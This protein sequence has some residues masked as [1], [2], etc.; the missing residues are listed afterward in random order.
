VHP[1]AAGQCAQKA[2][3]ALPRRQAFPT[4]PVL[5]A[6][7]GHAVDDVYPVNRIR[8]LVAADRS[9]VE[10]QIVPG[11]PTDPRELRAALQAQGVVHGLDEQALA[12]LGELLAAAEADGRAIVARA[13]PPN[14]GRDGRVEFAFATAPLP[15]Q[16]CGNGAVDFH[17]RELLHPAATGAEIARILPP[18]R[19]E[20]GHDVLGR[21]LPAPARKPAALRVGAGAAL[22]PD[23]RVLAVRDGFVATPAGAIDVLPLYAHKGD[24]DLKCGNL[25]SHGAVLVSGDLQQG[26]QIEADGDVAVAG[27]AFGGTIVAG[28]SVTVGFGAQAGSR[29]T[30]GGDLR[31]RHATNSTLL[32]AGKIEIRD[33]LVHCEAAAASIVLL[34]GRGSALGGALRARDRI[35][36]RSAGSPSG[37]PTLLAAGDLT[38]ERAELVRRKRQLERIERTVHRRGDADPARGKLLRERTAAADDAQKEKLDLLRRQR[39]LLCSARIE[40]HGRMHP[41]VRVQFGDAVLALT[42]ECQGM[43]FRFDAAAGT[44][45]Q[46]AR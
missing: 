8:V 4:A 26:F 40:V 25:H 44:I 31:C 7:R 21:P 29:I 18:E 35:A 20:D 45:V 36:L 9:A 22:Q 17:E 10:V 37:A 5:R 6:S 43:C 3:P 13:T 14:P 12:S 41:G 2:G 32:A 46:E 30:T 28:G 19:G 38:S 39:E 27:S 23:G 42:T 33:E 11:L 15:G 1:A 34:Q 24:V 16:Q